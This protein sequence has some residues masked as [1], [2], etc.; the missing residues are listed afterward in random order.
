[1]PD[2]KNNNKWNN[3]LYM[4]NYWRLLWQLLCTMPWPKNG[5][6]ADMCSMF[7]YEFPQMLGVG[8]KATPCEGN[9][10]K[11]TPS[12]FPRRVKRTG[13]KMSADWDWG[14]YDVEKERYKAKGIK[15]LPTINPQTRITVNLILK[16]LVLKTNLKTTKISILGILML[17]SSSKSMKTIDVGNLF[18]NL[19]LRS[20]RNNTLMW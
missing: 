13:T 2:N 12:Y 15:G 1:M 10:E 11:I 17:K 20:L 5:W 3:S 6:G 16:I 9:M 14:S 18:T 7:K 19:S 8:L 4:I